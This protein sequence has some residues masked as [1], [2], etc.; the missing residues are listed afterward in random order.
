MATASDVANGGIML[1]E[2]FRQ[3]KEITL[4]D[5]TTG[6]LTLG[7]DDNFHIILAYGMAYEYLKGKDMKRAEAIFR[8]I[9]I[10]IKNLRKHYSSKQLDRQYSLS[11]DYQSMK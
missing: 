5:L 2:W 8:D 6:T 11:G 10:Y 9:Q 3:A 1:V 4:S 7:F